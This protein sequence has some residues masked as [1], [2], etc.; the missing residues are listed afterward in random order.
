VVNPVADARIVGRNRECW[1]SNVRSSVQRLLRS[2][3][4]S[5]RRT[6]SVKLILFL[7]LIKQLNDL[8]VN[9]SSLPY[10]EFVSR[11]DSGPVS[12]GLIRD[13]DDGRG[14]GGFLTGAAGFATEIA[15]TVCPR[16]WFDRGCDDLQQ[17][18]RRQFR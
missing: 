4:G 10:H 13:F 16:S 11:N 9:L 17:L 1:D 3:L 12:G 5:A 6:L 2:R 14:V 7:Q 18:L 15:S 8:V